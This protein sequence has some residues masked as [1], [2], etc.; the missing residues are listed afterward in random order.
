MEDSYVW[1]DCMADFDRVVEN[2]ALFLEAA[3]HG[4]V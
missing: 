3:L 1:F 2:D 4:S